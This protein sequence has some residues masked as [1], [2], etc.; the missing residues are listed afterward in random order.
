[1]KLN[2]PCPT[3]TGLKTGVG[4]PALPLAKLR[5]CAIPDTASRSWHIWSQVT[6]PHLGQ[7]TNCNLTLLT[8][9]MFFK[10][11][12]WRLQL[13]VIAPGQPFRLQLWKMMVS[14]WDGCDAPFLDTLA[15]GVRLG[16][17]CS[18]DPSPA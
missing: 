7:R 18:L 13:A 17:N 12:I 10:W 2:W 11:N 6:R 8:C 1:M 9:W 5:G 15:E 14:T 16:V 4:Y 3:H